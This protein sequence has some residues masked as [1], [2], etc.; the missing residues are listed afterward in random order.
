M[1][2]KHRLT[3][4]LQNQQIAWYC[5]SHDSGESI[6]AGC[7]LHQLTLIPLLMP[8]AGNTEKSLSLLTYIPTCSQTVEGNR[9]G[10]RSA[11][12]AVY[13]RTQDRQME[14]H[15]QDT[16]KKKFTRPAGKEPHS[17]RET[18]GGEIRGRFWLM[19]TPPHD[20]PLPR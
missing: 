8:A 2:D 1:G 15:R 6:H 5:C 14:P 4:Q 9:A 20:S 13:T 7:S 19:P 17:G 18:G 12:R 3:A 16:K 10:N 11:A